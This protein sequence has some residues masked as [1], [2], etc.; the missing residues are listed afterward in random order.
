MPKREGL[1]M[2]LMIILLA[3]L[4]IGFL[5]TVLPRLLGKP[6]SF[7]FIYLFIKMVGLSLLGGFIIFLTIYQ[8]YDGLFRIFAIMAG[9]APLAMIIGIILHNLTCA[10]LTKLFGKEVEEPVFFLTAIFGCPTVF[11]VGI[12]GSLIIA[13]R[14][15][16]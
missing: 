7:K 15:I 14:T 8:D 16:I 4:L 10:L 6:K 12:V 1:I 2:K 11:L 3:V 13:I 5:V 9:I